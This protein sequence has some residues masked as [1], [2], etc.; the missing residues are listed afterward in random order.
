M[1]I[2]ELPPVGMRG[3]ILST[4]Y[5]APDN[6]Q[7]GGTRPASEPSAR[8]FIVLFGPLAEEVGRELLIDS[9]VSDAFGMNATIEDLRVQER[10]LALIARAIEYIDR[11]GLNSKAD[12]E[13]REG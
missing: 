10:A 12:A 11:E 1:R 6:R 9:K 13:Y 8:E 5:A 2:R 4:R 7:N 3:F